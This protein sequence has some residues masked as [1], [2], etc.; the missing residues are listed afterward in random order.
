MHN[1]STPSPQ[2][3]ALHI[4][5]S[6]SF[7]GLASGSTSTSHTSSLREPPAFTETPGGSPTPTSS[8]GLKRSAA[9]SAII[10][11][12][13]KRQRLNRPTDGTKLD[14]WLR[15]VKGCSQD[16]LSSDLDKGELELQDIAGARLSEG[17]TGPPD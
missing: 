17:Q 14:A 1:L 10:E 12:S 7:A 15:A 4:T 11:P 8:V 9:H 2:G 3:T 6:S 13:T 16:Q 5:P